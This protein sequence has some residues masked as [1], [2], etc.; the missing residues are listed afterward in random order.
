MYKTLNHC[1]GKNLLN[2]FK[3]ALCLANIQEVPNL[4][5]SIKIYQTGCL[6]RLRRGP[7]WMLTP[8]LIVTSRSDALARKLNLSFVIIFNEGL[9][10]L[11]N[12]LY[13]LR[14]YKF[15]SSNV[16]QLQNRVTF[17]KHALYIVITSKDGD[18][19]DS[20]KH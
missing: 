12:W 17:R 10:A 3:E 1:I 20:N 11:E 7:V 15:K 14:P 9:P 5:R 2:Y 6:L 13:A 16:Q 18:W 4:P 8:V 19:T